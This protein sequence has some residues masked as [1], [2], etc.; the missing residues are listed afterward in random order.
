MNV[1]PASLPTETVAHYMTRTHAAPMPATA[2]HAN[3]HPYTPTNTRRRFT[4]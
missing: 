3:R 2:H 4:R 1:T